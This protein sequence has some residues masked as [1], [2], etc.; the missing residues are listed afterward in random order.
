MFFSGDGR[1]QTGVWA[2]EYYIVGKYTVM[3]LHDKVTS[4]INFICESTPSE[5]GPIQQEPPMWRLT[6]ACT[7]LLCNLVLS[8]QTSPRHPLLSLVPGWESIHQIT[9]GY[10]CISSRRWA[11]RALKPERCWRLNQSPPIRGASN[12]FKF[13]V[14]SSEFHQ[15]KNI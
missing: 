3:R 13:I 5:T 1:E 15:K 6:T 12:S 14:M 11:L 4:A 7:S 8:Q 9:R 2:C 10:L